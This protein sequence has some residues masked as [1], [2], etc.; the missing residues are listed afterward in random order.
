MTHWRAA[1]RPAAPG[2]GAILTAHIR[3]GPIIRRVLVRQIA[4]LNYIN[5]V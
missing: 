1:F 3:P 2:T 4:I 5:P